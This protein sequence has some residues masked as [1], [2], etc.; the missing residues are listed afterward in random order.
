MFL[1]KFQEEANIKQHSNE[2]QI[3]FSVFSLRKNYRFKLEHGTGSLHWRALVLSPIKDIL[4]AKYILNCFCSTE[5]ANSNLLFFSLWKASVSREFISWM[6]CWF[7]LPGYLPV[8]W[9]NNS[10]CSG[11]D[12]AFLIN[13]YGTIKG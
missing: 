8:A 11:I 13:I 9:S 12:L 7:C 2:I 5:L 6:F 1:R 4:A 10:R 3:L